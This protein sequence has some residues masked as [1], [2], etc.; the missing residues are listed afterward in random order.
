MESEMSVYKTFTT[1][2][3]FGPYITKLIL[4]FNRKISKQSVKP[5]DFRV[6][7][8]RRNPETKA[9]ILTKEFFRWDDAPEPAEG[10]R[11]V[12]RAYP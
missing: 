9:V 2:T 10:E 1:V 6:Q 12:Y 11:Q 4:K 5:E 3:D 8:R 7:V